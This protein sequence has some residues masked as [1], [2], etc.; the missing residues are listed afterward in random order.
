M[1]INL[2]GQPCSGKSTLSKALREKL[3]SIFEGRTIVIIDG[4]QF[5]KVNDNTDYT[6]LGRLNNIRKAYQVAENIELAG[7]QDENFNPII[8][9]ALVSPFMD[10]RENLKAN[11]EVLEVFLHSD[12]QERKQYHTKEF[13]E[14]QTNCIRMN[15][16][17]ITVPFCI[18]I[19]MMW[20]KE[21]SS[22]WQKNMIS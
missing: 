2:V 8:I 12:R 18:E 22:L 19:I 3:Q 11:N 14:P 20:L 6:P 5:R 15:T 7:K 13:E 10:I 1:I 21:K 4:D 16:S 17:Q 9:L